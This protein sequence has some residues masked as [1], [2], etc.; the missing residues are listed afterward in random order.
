M[1]TDHSA[2]SLKSRILSRHDIVPRLIFPS[3]VYGATCAR[4]HLF[5]LHYIIVGWLLSLSISNNWNK[6]PTY[7]TKNADQQQ[8]GRL[9]MTQE[10]NLY[11]IIWQT[12]SGHTTIPKYRPEQLESYLIS[13]K[14]SDAIPFGLWLKKITTQ[15]DTFPRVIKP[16][17]QYLINENRIS[18][19]REN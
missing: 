17:T 7:L 10:T 8:L 4:L 1:Q 2:A 11:T 3:K 12:P 5:L 15:R 6:F 9:P 18:P 13:I 16:D 19:R 14:P